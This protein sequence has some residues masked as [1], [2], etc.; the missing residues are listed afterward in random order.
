[1]PLVEN[2]VY[3][4]DGTL[5]GML[6]CIFSSY[7]HHELPSAVL[8]P[9]NAQGSLFETRIIPSDPEKAARVLHGLR[10][11]AG[12]E[13]VDL[14]QLCHLTALPEKERHCLMFV[15]IAMKYGPA[16][17]SML[18]VPHVLQITQAVRFLQTEAHH[19][20]GFV[21]FADIDGTLVSMITPKNDVL[22]LLAGHF[23]DRFPEERFIIYDRTRRL[24]L[25]HLPGETRIVPLKELKL[26]ALS[27]QELN[28]QALWQRFHQT[29]AIDG[30]LNRELQR[31]LLPLRFRPDMT[32]FQEGAASPTIISPKGAL[33]Q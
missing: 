23:A 19:L 17:V 7:E 11:K 30:R 26:P 8:S 3:R 5:D 1:M 10:R 24:A 29:I 25:M 32:E 18:T 6:C 20:C 27:A 15:R 14:V 21:R 33:P 12:D 13:A 4:Y 31:T 9:D 2:I 22:P 16:A 28:V